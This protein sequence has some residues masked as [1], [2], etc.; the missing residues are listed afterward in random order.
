MREKCYPTNT[1][2][3]SKMYTVAWKSLDTPE[4]YLSFLRW[5]Y[6]WCPVLGYFFSL[7]LLSIFS[8]NVVNLLDFGWEASD[9]DERSSVSKVELF[10]TD[11][12]EHSEEGKKKSLC[13]RPF[14]AKNF[15]S[16]DVH[17]TCIENICWEGKKYSLW[18]RVYRHISQQ[19]FFFFLFFCLSLLLFF[20]VKELSLAHPFLRYF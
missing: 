19:F 20:F 9:I 8:V 10:I 12:C 6:P 18:K 3:K 1:W 7:V 17:W 15:V 5:K 2:K 14:C 11:C 16:A 4:E 13:W